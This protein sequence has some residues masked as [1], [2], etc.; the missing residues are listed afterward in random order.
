MASQL[1]PE[2]MADAYVGAVERG[3]DGLA[4]WWESRL[5]AVDAALRGR[6]Q[7]PMLLSDSAAWYAQQGLP[8]FP[9]QPGT[10]IP[11]PARLNCC[12]GSHRRG[13]LDALAHVGAARAWWREHPT[14]NIGLATGHRVD[15]ID[16]DGTEGARRWC[17][18][19]DW[20]P[21]LG[22]VS[23]PRAGGVHRFVRATGRGNGQRIAPGL[24]YRGRGGYVVAPPSVVEGRRYTWLRAL[25]LRGC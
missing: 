6:L 15:V 7:D 19:G 23:T 18:G 13:C 12:G 17:R 1:S 4:A 20:P 10:K 21:V 24:D 8:I 22:V 25:D 2:Q 9:L 16:Q 11:L 3:A 5:D 14:A